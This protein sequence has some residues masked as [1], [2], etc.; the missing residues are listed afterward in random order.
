MRLLKEVVSGLLEECDLDV[1]EEHFTV[2]AGHFITFLI[3]L[4]NVLNA[5]GLFSQQ[6]NAGFEGQRV[7]GV[8]AELRV[9]KRPVVFQ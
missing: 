3:F 9:N 2:V 4:F 6:V 1:G 8:P 7:C 5:C